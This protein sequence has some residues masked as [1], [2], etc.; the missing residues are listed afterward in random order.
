MKQ[1]HTRLSSHAPILD[2]AP[3]S[4]EVCCGI[5]SVRGRS[6][7][8][9]DYVTGSE[10]RDRRPPP[11]GVDVDYP[12]GTAPAVASGSL[13]VG[14]VSLTPAKR[15]ATLATVASMVTGSGFGG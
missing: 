12:P 15:A 6:P 8:L 14:M 1:F 3:H 5:G 11:D 7:S 13:R 10:A 9:A 4:L 2:A